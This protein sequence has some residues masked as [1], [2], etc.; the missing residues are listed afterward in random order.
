MKQKKGPVRLSLGAHYPNAGPGQC[1]FNRR[2][3]VKAG[4]SPGQR[5]KPHSVCLRAQ[6]DL[7]VERRLP[8]IKGAELPAPPLLIQLGERE[9][10][11]EGI[12]GGSERRGFTVKT[13][14][15]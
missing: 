11:G 3:P 12:H 1:G 14:G 15:I 4:S 2:L 9:R 5:T 8:G 6:S 10:R 13:G 7:G